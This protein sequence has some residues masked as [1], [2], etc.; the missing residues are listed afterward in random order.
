MQSADVVRM[1]V[2]LIVLAASP[3]VRG[4]DER[5]GESP[6]SSAAAWTDVAIRRLEMIK[7]GTAIGDEPPAGWSHLVLL[8]KP[9]IAVGDVQAIPSSAMHYGSMFSF[10]ILANVRAEGGADG[11]HRQYFLER[12]AIGMATDVQGRN[13]VVTSDQTAGADVGFIGRAVMRENDRIL[14]TDMRQVARTR[15][16][17]LFDANAMMLRNK[18]HQA[19]VVRHA[20]VVSPQTGQL[21]AF[22]WLL[23][24]DGQDR[25]ALAENAVQMLPPKMHEDRILSVDSRKFTLGIPSADAFAL[26][27]MPPG[28]PVKYSKSLATLAALRRFTPETALRLEDELQKRYAPLALRVHQPGS[29]RR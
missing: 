6:T 24:R 20:I 17:E 5:R 13:L 11:E 25:Y 2:P 18:Q 9:R 29:A 7:P 23:T 8:A 12:V 28:T 4:G 22:V 21:T 14:Q 15:T 19:M 27:R 10:T 1:A 3:L 16:M 26:A